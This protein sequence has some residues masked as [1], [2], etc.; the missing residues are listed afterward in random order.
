MHS[1]ETI[2]EIAKKYENVKEFDKIARTHSMVE[3]I[4][5][6]ITDSTRKMIDN[7]VKIDELDRKAESLKGTFRVYA[8]QCVPIRAERHRARKADV[9]EKLQ[10]KDHNRNRNRGHSGDD[11]R[12]DRH[13]MILHII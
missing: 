8:R 10:T 7:S 2:S 9:L 6:S 4:R 3:E 11:H 5:D 13:Q 1:K 12:A